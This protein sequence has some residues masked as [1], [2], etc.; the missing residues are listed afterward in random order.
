MPDLNGKVAVVTGATGRRGLALARRYARDGAS[1]VLDG[2]RQV[3]LDDSMFATS[4][5][6][7][8]ESG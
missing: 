1:V 5:A 8:R 4:A 2:R 6:S 3:A 7:L